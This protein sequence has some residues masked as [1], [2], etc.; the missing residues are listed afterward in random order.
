MIWEYIVCLGIF[1]TDISD[2]ILEHSEETILYLFGYKK[3][4]GEGMVHEHKFQSHNN[5]C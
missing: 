5:K 2:E 3:R 4:M 1:G